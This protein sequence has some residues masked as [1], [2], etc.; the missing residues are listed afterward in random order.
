[1]YNACHSISFG[2]WLVLVEMKNLNKTSSV[3]NL[4]LCISSWDSCIGRVWRNVVYNQY[5]DATWKI[6]KY[7]VR[8]SSLV[9]CMIGVL[10]NRWDEMREETTSDLFASI[11]GIYSFIKPSKWFFLGY[12]YFLLLI[13]LN[14]NFN[15]SL[16]SESSFWTKKNQKM[17]NFLI[18][19]KLL[20]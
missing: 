13:F 14:L 4:V 8:L 9:L 12:C 16:N 19:H 3:S 1:M 5:F 7:P 10:E 11:L 6:S 18:W 20:I 15:S 2:L 17:L